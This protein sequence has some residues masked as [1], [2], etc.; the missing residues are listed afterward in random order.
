[1]TAAGADTRGSAVLARPGRLSAGMRAAIGAGAVANLLWCAGYIAGAGWATWPWDTGR[2]SH[3]FV[4]SMLA[5]IGAGAAWIAYSGEVGSLPAGFL[6]LTVALGGIAGYLLS[7]GV[8]GADTRLGYVAAALAILNALLFAWS[9]RWRAPRREPLPT[10]VRGSYVA[11]AVVLLVVGVLLILRTD[12]I[13]PWPVDADTSVVFGWIFFGDAWYFGYAAAIA[14]WNA[15]RSQLWSFLGY[16]A[17][18]LIPL[19]LH[20]A[21][22]PAELRNNLLLY[23][24]VLVYST[25][26]GLYYLV[27]NPRTR[28]WPRRVA[29]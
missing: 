22:V 29:A 8:A 20:V 24:A 14:D 12:G 23:L 5:A 6:N 27:V 17:V 16:N 15:A 19:L 18:L 21:A 10:L 2:L 3:L 26:L 7:G 11:F 28:G 13:M 4:A 25:A 9:L 1:M